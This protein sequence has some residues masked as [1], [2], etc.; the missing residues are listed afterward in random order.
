MAN[1]SLILVR[2]FLIL[3]DILAIPF[4]LFFGFWIKHESPFSEEFIST[5]WVIKASILIG[6]PIY[7]FTGQYKSLTRYVGSKSLYYLISRNTLLTI[8]IIIYGKLFKLSLPSG[9]NLITFLILVSFVSG[10][11]RFILRDFLLYFPILE[12]KILKK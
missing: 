9:G 1:L 2:L 7:L 8:I 5:L 6:I 11:I 3:I 12:R 10:G 4:V